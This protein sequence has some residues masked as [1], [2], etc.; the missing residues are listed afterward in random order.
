MSNTTKGKRNG[1]FLRHLKRTWVLYLFIVPMV[2]YVILFSYVPMYGIQLAFKDYRPTDGIWGSAWV[3][4]EHFKLFVNLFSLKI[5]C[6]IR[7][8]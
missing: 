4:L 8:H 5:C 3:G 7:Y 2:I 1:K 6:G